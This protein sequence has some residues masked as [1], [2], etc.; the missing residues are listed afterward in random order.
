MFI[1]TNMGVNCLSVNEKHKPASVA[2]HEKMGLN[3]VGHFSEVGLKFEQWVD[4]TYWQGKL[5]K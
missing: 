1:L 4:V 3:K 5:K 2:L